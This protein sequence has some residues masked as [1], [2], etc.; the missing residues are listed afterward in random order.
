[1]SL[2][3]TRKPE[4]H[5][6]ASVAP[7]CEPNRVQTRPFGKSRPS[8][9]NALHSLSEVQRLTQSSMGSAAGERN[10]PRNTPAGMR[11]PHN[12]TNPGAR[13]GR[14]VGVL[15]KPVGMDVAEAASVARAALDSATASPRLNMTA[16]D[17]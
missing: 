13:A 1:M 2:L 17:P 3:G 8:R 4:I 15:Q 12:S 11:L 9:E 7:S 10:E 16:N 5:A 14:V 6:V